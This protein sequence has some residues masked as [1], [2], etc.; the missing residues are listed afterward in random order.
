[1]GLLGSTV[2]LHTWIS[3]RSCRDVLLESCF[4]C[5]E[6]TREDETWETKRMK[7]LAA[8]WDKAPPAGE[9]EMRVCRKKQRVDYWLGALTCLKTPSC[10]KDVARW[11]TGDTPVWGPKQTIAREAGSAPGAPPHVRS[12]LTYA[13]KTS[14]TC[15]GSPAS[16][17]GRWC[18][19]TEC[20]SF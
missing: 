7:I 12:C 9:D 11:A 6:K 3:E 14:Y 16:A 4:S 18:R 1:M 8:D 15:F 5:S 13:K 2:S 20:P 10:G 17:D 19:M